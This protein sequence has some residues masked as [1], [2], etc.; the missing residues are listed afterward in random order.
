MG[1]DLKNRILASASLLTVLGLL[2]AQPEA[3]ALEL[4][5]SS[6]LVTGSGPRALPLQDSPGVPPDARQVAES[7]KKSAD[8]IKF[9]ENEGQWR[10]EVLF[11]LTTEAGRISIERDKLVFEIVHRKA[12]PPANPE[13]PAADTTNRRERVTQTFAFHF[14]GG[15]PNPVIERGELFGTTYN[16]LQGSDRS[17]WK[18][19]VRA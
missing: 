14:D 4:P 15:N 7:L 17:R 2:F 12:Q 5:A 18:T 13:D 8:T 11:S 6:D 9:I 19:G 10:P 16:Y 3:G 1:F